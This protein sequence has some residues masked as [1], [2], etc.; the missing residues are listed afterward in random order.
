MAS[1][2]RRGARIHCRPRESERCR[3]WTYNRREQ[4]KMDEGAV[5]EL[6][7]A[8]RQLVRVMQQQSIDQRSQYRLSRSPGFNPTSRNANRYSGGTTKFSSARFPKSR[9]I[10]ASKS[11]DKLRT[12][13]SQ[14]E[15]FQ[16]SA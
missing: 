16:Q 5:G 2:I 4:L 6:I 13:P 9:W 11:Y 10:P 3:F 14:N 12:L 7:M 1:A 15:M 8:Y